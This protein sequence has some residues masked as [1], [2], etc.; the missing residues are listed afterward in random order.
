MLDI[1]RTLKQDRLLRALTGLNRKA[2][3]A[4]LPTFSEIYEQTC[5]SQPRQRAV[6]GGRKARLSRIQDKLFFILFYFKCYPTFDVAGLV[7]DIHRSQAHE[8]MHRLQTVLE[9]ALEQKM[10]LPERKLDSVE[11]F[12]ERFSRVKRVMIDGTERPIQRPQ[13]PEQQQLNYSGKKKRH[14]RKHLAAIDENKRVLVLS[15]A[16]EGKLHDK[17]FHDEDDIASNV[18]DEIPIEVDL[19]FQGLQKQYDNIYLPHKKPRGG[20]LNDVQK[21]ENRCLSQS[22]VLCENAFAGVKR[23]NAVSQTYRNRTKNFDDNL[24]LTAAGLWN[25]YLIAA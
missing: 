25:F 23:Y 14:M 13:D 22:R 10:V 19:G 2:F 4:L 16:R 8:W 21:Q 1:E 12:Q 15:H 9:T 6:G 24:M 20:E 3:D 17:R 7:F 5:R 11:A 18:P